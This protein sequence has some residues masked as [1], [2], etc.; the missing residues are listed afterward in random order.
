[1]KTS[2]TLF[3]VILTS[4]SWSQVLLKP[5]ELPKIN[6]I[7]KLGPAR[8]FLIGDGEVNVAGTLIKRVE[9]GKL[10]AVITYFNKGAKS[11]QPK[12]T[13]RLINAYG[14]EVTS[15]KDEWHVQGVPAG[16]VAKE[17]ASFYSNDIDR[18]LQFTTISLPADWKTPIYF[19]IEG[20]EP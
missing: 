9:L 13:F 7:E 16:E 11:R 14:M 18:Q 6:L 1:M 10:S 2:V 3:V 20:V 12:F 4:I 8:V 15:F 5:I 17:E 19:L